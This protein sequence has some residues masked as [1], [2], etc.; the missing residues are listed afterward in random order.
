MPPLPSLVVAKQIV[1]KEG[2]K[3]VIQICRSRDAHLG[4]ADLRLSAVR[5]KVL[6]QPGAY[7]ALALCLVS[8]WC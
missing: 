2:G 4:K 6:H 8:G 1:S 7:L 5:I 3:P